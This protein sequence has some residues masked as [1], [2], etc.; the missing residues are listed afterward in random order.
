MFKHMQKYIK[1]K[2]RKLLKNLNL[3]SV[4]FKNWAYLQQEHGNVSVCFFQ[5]EGNFAE[6][7]LVS[8]DYAA[9]LRTI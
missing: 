6:I 5:W 3:Q 2:C 9:L 4:K 7:C 1:R 8:L